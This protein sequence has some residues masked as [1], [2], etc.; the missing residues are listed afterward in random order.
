MLPIV[1]EYAVQASSKA[2]VILTTHS[3]QLLDA[4]AETK[5]RTTV[6]QRVDGETHLHVL[7]E[8]QLSRWLENY[9][10]GALHR[11]GELEEMVP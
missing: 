3:P 10:L 6:V 9:S 4:F 11:S 8:A 2:Q 1:A 7:D 5:P